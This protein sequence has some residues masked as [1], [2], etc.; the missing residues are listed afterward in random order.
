MQ[1]QHIQF[2]RWLQRGVTAWWAARKNESQHCSDCDAAVS[3]WDQFCPDCGLES[4][5]RVRISP[6]V[7]AGIGLG[8]VL[9]LAVLRWV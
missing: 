2:G 9:F 1:H 8:V 4:P 3:P 7:Y 5:A 6:L